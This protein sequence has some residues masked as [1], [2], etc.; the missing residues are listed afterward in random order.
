MGEVAIARILVGLD[1]SDG[2]AVALRWAIHVARA[3]DAEVLAV[4]AFELP[5]PVIAPPVGVG[6]GLGVEELAV[7]EELRST[8]ERVFETEWAAPLAKA[9][10][11]HRR[12]FE[13]GR[14]ADVLLDVAERENVDLLVTGR[15]GRG[16]LASLLAGSVSQE[17]IHRARVPVTVVPHTD[18]QR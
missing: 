11:R 7:E 3:V 4:H 17:L 1:G 10:T 9:G 14:P 18:D 5:Q 13:E 15:R 12:L 6:V 8:A 16:A 2:S